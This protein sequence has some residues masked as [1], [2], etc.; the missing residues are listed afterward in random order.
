MR[1]PTVPRN[2]I[3]PPKIKK[4]KTRVHS[5]QSVHRAVFQLPCHL[6][7]DK[8]LQYTFIMLGLYVKK[9]LNCKSCSRIQM[10]RIDQRKEANRILCLQVSAPA[11]SWWCCY[12]CK[13]QEKILTKWLYPKES[14]EVAKVI[15]IHVA[16]KMN[17]CCKF[18]C[19][20][21][22][23]RHFTSPKHSNVNLMV[24][25]EVW[26]WRCGVLQEVTE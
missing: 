3:S 1:L 16:W 21:V 17:L 6:I 24:M 5:D 19:I 25:E 10:K 26:G 8:V 4:T 20:Q 23:M 14:Q 15:R 7:Y 12:F 18:Q 11:N 13:Y 9:W 22:V 2:P